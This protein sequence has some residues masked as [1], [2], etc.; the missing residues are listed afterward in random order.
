M[1]KRALAWPRRSASTRSKFAGGD[2]RIGQLKLQTGDPCRI[3]ASFLRR[4]VDQL[5]DRDRCFLGPAKSSKPND[6][7]DDPSR[8]ALLFVALGDDLDNRHIFCPFQQRRHAATAL[9]ASVILFQAIRMRS[10]RRAFRAGPTALAGCLASHCFFRRLLGCC[11]GGMGIAHVLLP[12]AIKHS[13]ANRIGVLT[14]LY[15]VLMTVS[16]ALPSL[17]A[18]PM[19]EA[20]GW[21]ASVGMWSL[22]GSAA[23]LSWLG[24]LQ[25]H[26]PVDHSRQRSSYAA[27]RWPAVYQDRID[28]ES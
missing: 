22:L 1:P 4:Q 19:T 28:R 14:S 15:M 9:R 27:C 2:L 16:A 18:V 23:A 11:R 17:L 25:A 7:I 5:L 8:D 6:D 13:F 10:R 24:L 3:L 21:G 20:V 26:D 12:P